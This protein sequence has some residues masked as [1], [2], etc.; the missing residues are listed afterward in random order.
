MKLDKEF[1]EAISNLPSKEK[2][3]LL[4]RLLKKDQTLANRLY[5]ELVDTKSLE[6]KR[7]EMELFVKNQT[8]QMSNNYYSPGYLHMD[9]RYLSGEISEY[10]KI[11]RD[12]FGE[13]CLNLL[14]LNEVLKL[15]NEKLVNVPYSKAY[16]C[17][18]YIIARSFKI[19]ILI[20]KLHDDFLMELEDDLK[21]LGME[22]GKNDFLMK[23]AIHNGFDVNW[24]INAEIPDNII[25]I[26]KDIRS[27]GFLK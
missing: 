9:M 24:L 20:N 4:F 14:M 7:Q 26:H 25:Q 2:D 16:K 1:K 13:V 8:V 6:E 21:N 23:T 15:N 12:R 17:C 27:Q 10:V 5:F 19:A 18:L 11:T 22:I 3:K